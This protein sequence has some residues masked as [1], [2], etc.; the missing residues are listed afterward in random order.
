MILGLDEGLP[1]LGRVLVAF[2][3]GLLPGWA[4]EHS[5]RASGL[6][7][8]P[9]VAV[10]ACGFL[11][12]GRLGLAANLGAQANV[13]AALLTGIGFL[14]SGVILRGRGKIRGATDAVGF[15]VATA[16]G[17]AAAYDLFGLAAVMSLLTF[18]ALRSHRGVEKE[19]R[20]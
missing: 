2:A 15:W 5:R 13:V 12:A 7:T 18:A 8:Y 14:G 16:I 20:R 10:G 11:S 4:R 9:L 1:L 6:R 19:A 17:A 3:L